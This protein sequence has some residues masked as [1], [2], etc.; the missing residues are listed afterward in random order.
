MLLFLVVITV[1][2]ARQGAALLL[3]VVFV[4]CRERYN[5]LFL[6]ERMYIRPFQGLGTPVFELAVRQPITKG[7]SRIHLCMRE[8]N[9]CIVRFLCNPVFEDSLN[10]CWFPGV[11]C[12]KKVILAAQVREALFTGSYAHPLSNR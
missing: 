3:K 2:V 10:I 6:T 5:V 4:F 1:T 7:R 12:S 9:I 8:M 11:F